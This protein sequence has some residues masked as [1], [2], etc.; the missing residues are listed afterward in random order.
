[1]PT[2][3]M[4]RPYLPGDRPGTKDTAGLGQD[5]SFRAPRRISMR[6][7]IQAEETHL[8]EERKQAP[9]QDGATL[10][11]DSKETQNTGHSA[12]SGLEDTRVCMCDSRA[13]L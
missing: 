13:H 8:E 1:M 10:H 6:C 7:S 11:S 4:P 2:S 3:K 5:F 9:H 12:P